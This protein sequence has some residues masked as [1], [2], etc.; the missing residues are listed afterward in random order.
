MVAPRRATSRRASAAPKIPTDRDP[1]NRHPVLWHHRAAWTARTQSSR[2]GRTVTASPNV[3]PRIVFKHPAES[4]LAAQLAPSYGQRGR[5]S[6]A[7]LF[8][9]HGPSQRLK[10]N[11]SGPMHRGTAELLLELANNATVQGIPVVPRRN[12]VATTSV[13]PREV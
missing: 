7:D 8:L 11:A 6:L 10:A 13:T 4:A 3:A 9:E 1:Q 12:L 2:H 5:P